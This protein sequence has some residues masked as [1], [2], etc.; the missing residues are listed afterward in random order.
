MTDQ[1]MVGA[2]LV[3][4]SDPVG[5]R[6]KGKSFLAAYRDQ[7]FFLGFMAGESDPVLERPMEGEINAAGQP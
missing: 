3:V 5:N 2:S 4:D 1:T 7:T 6:E